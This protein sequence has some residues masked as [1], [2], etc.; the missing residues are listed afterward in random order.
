MPLTPY[1]ERK[2]RIRVAGH[3]CYT[4]VHA[5][6]WKEGANRYCSTGFC[7]QHKC[8]VSG[9]SWCKEWKAVTDV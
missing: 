3:S 6:A 7:L 4:C 2:P 1:D 5:T 9:G 8:G